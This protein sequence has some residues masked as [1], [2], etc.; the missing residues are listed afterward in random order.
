LR[1][2]EAGSGAALKAVMLGGR[3]ITD[4]PTAFTEQHSGQLE[5]IF[6]T[7]APSLEGAVT[8]Q[9]GKP[10]TQAT[11]LIFG[12]NP[13]TWVPLSSYFRRTPLDEDGRF[14]LTGLRE[15]SYFAVALGPEAGEGLDQ[16]TKEFLESLSKVATRV[17]LNPGE[18]RT[19]DLPLVRFE[20]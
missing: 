12:E 15:G 8:D 10:P 6:T 19:V 11:V 3:D 4:V 20:Q 9:F 14:T 16:P 1:G 2:S 17:V 13:A 5:V 7:A 18:T